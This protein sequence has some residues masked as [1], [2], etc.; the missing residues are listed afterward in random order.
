MAFHYSLE[1]GE[2]DAFI[3]DSHVDARN[4]EVH[5]LGVAELLVDFCIRYQ[6]IEDRILAR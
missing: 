2:G 6:D 5:A 3:L 4:K 1:D